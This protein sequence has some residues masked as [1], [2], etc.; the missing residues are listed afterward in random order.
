MTRT[1][2]S[3]YNMYNYFLAYLAWRIFQEIPE[4]DRRIDIDMTLFTFYIFTDNFL[5]QRSGLSSSFDEYELAFQAS[6]KLSYWLI[7]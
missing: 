4:S 7:S 3:I 6:Q 5:N 1:L 2:Y